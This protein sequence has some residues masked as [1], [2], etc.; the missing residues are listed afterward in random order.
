MDLL[1]SPV[2]EWGK[3]QVGPGRSRVNGITSR[4]QVELAQNHHKLE[5]LPIASPHH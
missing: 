5:Q 4:L 1:F 2:Q 3:P